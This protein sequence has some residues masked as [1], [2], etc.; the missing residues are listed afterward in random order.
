MPVGSKIDFCEFCVIWAGQD[1]DM[2]KDGTDQDLE[3]V[4]D[5]SISGDLNLIEGMEERENGV[6][7]GRIT[8]PWELLQPVLRILGHCL[9][10]P[11]KEDKALR[12]AARGACRN[13]YA[14]ALHD[15]NP[16][17]ILATGSLLRLGKMAM[18]SNDD[19]DPTELPKDDVLNL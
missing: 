1:G 19:F 12:E 17:A 7:E 13:L 3:K 10:G 16:K 8:L 18:E 6:K 5:E 2:Y 4:G 15:V 9:M 14:R 11:D